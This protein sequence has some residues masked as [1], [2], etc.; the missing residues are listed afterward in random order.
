MKKFLCMLSALL[1]AG[2]L[3]MAPAALADDKKDALTDQKNQ[4]QQEYNQ[5]QQELKDLQNKTNQTKNEI[6]QLQGQAA[7]IAAQIT[8]VTAA[9][10]EAQ[11]L[12]AERRQLAE[13]AAA[14][15]AQKQDEYDASLERCKTQMGAMQMLDNGGAIA[16]LAQASSLYEILTFDETL[17]QMSARNSAVLTELNDEAI[18]LDA[19]RQAADTA[20]QEAEAAEAALAEQEAQLT[21]SQNRLQ[22]ALQQAN[23]TLSAQQ[24]AQDAQSIVAQAA[25]DA[26]NKA[27]AELDAYNRSQGQK[28]GQGLRLTSLDFANPL[29]GHYTI[30]NTYAASDPW[31]RFHYGT[32]F[33]APQG[34]PIY[35]AADGIVSVA[36]PHYSYGNYV[37][38]THGYADDGNLY[39]TLYAH[40]TN[41]VV[42]AGTAVTKGQ[43]LGYVGNTG[44][45]WGANGGYHLHLEIHINGKRASSLNYIPY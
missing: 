40:M 32:D 27:V 33:A 38:V 39:E 34:T 12:V 31:G 19:A 13:E 15:L 1:L 8:T 41:Y 29:P 2:S 11:Q 4:A 10:M 42:S 3:F 30:T 16:F 5:A 21:D 7:E 36:R 45:V 17:R 6:G 18:A 28:Y 14:A 37:M 26:Y 20:Q 25:R 44:D 35:A 24:A 22:Q 43:L 23:A 9:K